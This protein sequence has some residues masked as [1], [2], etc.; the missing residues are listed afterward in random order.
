MLTKRI[1]NAKQMLGEAAEELDVDIGVFAPSICPHVWIGINVVNQEEIDRDVPKLRALPA[2]K[3]FLSIEPMLGP[4]DLRLG[5]SNDTGRWDAFGNPLPL[6]KIDWVIAGGESG[7]NARPM[8][9]DWV[10]DVR[11]QCVAAGTAFFFKQ[12]GCWAPGSKDFRSDDAVAFDG[13]V[14]AD[15]YDARTYPKG[16]ESADQWSMVHRTSN[17]A[18]GRQLYG[19]EWSEFPKYRAGAE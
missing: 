18:A 3:R 10:R 6:R 7:R 14:A 5:W 8:H 4:V 15:G 17:E 12:W 9:P 11:D 1:G 13:R 2:A 19:R 16:A